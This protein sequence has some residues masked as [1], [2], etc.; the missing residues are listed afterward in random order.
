M[1]YKSEKG[2]E[3]KAILKVLIKMLWACYMQI[4]I[5]GISRYSIQNPNSITL[6]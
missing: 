4:V 5:L 1:F 2:S 3:E 6:D